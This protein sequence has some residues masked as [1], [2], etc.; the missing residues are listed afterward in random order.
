[1][2][3]SKA[4]SI[5]IIVFL[6]LDIFL[7]ALYVNR[8]TE[9]VEVEVLGEKTIEAKLK[10]DNITFGTL[11]NIEKSKYIYAS[12]KT[13][14]KDELNLNN[15]ENVTI[16]GKSKLI[17]SLKKPVKIK[18]IEDVN[19][20]NDFVT[21]NVTS[22]TSYQLWN[23]DEKNRTATFFQRVKDQMIYYN[24]NG[25]V[26]LYWNENEEIYMYEQTMLEDIE[27]YDE[28]E[29]LLTP[30]Q[31]FRALYA[32]GSLKPNSNIIEVK[33]G[34]STLVQ[35]TKTQVFVPTWEI[36]VKRE[37]ETIEEYFVNAVE[38]KVIDVQTNVTNENEEETNQLNEL[39][40]KDV[41]E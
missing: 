4:K 40:V 21:S 2:D 8:H 30:I 28:D 35:L 24:I 25:V 5:F 20:F 13:F 34:Y 39:D 22:G 23:V 9:A 12:V 15:V 41:L 32:K 26:T 1:M 19:S 38:G 37:D 36:R 17:V 31:A 27:E 18:N 16:N 6:I 29:T 14:Q 33:L 7:Y 10:E 3:W 11:P